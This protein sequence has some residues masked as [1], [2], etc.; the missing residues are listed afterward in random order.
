MSKGYECHLTFDIESVKMVEASCPYGWTF[1]QIEGD[2]VLGQRLYC[3]WTAWNSSQGVMES[4]M[5]DAIN[6]AKRNGLP[7]VRAKIEHIIYDQRY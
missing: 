6:L 2:P 1:S 3:Y 5:R 7:L 4:T